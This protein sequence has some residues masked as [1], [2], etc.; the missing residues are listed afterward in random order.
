VVT[1]FS[2]SAG[3]STT[4]ITSSMKGGNSDTNKFDLDKNNIL[5][6][7]FN[8]LME[9]GRKAFEAYC[10]DLEELFL[11]HCKVMQHGTVLQDTTPIIFCKPEV[12]PEVWPDP[13]SSH[14][15]IQSMINSALEKQVNDTDELLRMLIE[16]RGGK[17]LDN[18]NVNSSSSCAVNF[19]Q[20][21]PHT[22][23][24][25]M[26]DTTMPNREPLSQPNHHRGFV[27][28]FWGGVTNYNHLVRARIYANRT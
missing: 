15:N 23:G 7:T 10:V 3:E 6:P 12:T 2:D 20:T 11:S 16:E 27:S 9:E 13:P 5:K 8:T 28:Y 1:Y 25:S 19:P 21:N 26:S 17:K 22:S 24:T 18:F 14:N 4:S